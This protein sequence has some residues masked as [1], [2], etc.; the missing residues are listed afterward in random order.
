MNVRS[1]F[2]I[3]AALALVINI[4]ASFI[5]FGSLKSL[6]PGSNQS[7]LLSYLSIFAIIVFSFLLFLISMVSGS[8][9]P[10]MTGQ[11]ET[12]AEMEEENASSAIGVSPETIINIEELKNIAV[13]FIPKGAVKPDE[14]Y[15]LKNFAEETLSQIARSYP[16]IEGL[17]YIK[18]KESDEFIPIGDY[19]YFS[20]KKPTGFKLGETLAGQVAKNKRALNISD[21]PVNYVKAASGLGEGSPLHLYFLPL[22][23]NEETIA[24]IEIAS[25]KELGK[26]SDTLFELAS[27]ELSKALVQ[28]QTRN[29]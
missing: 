22:I 16:I 21:I 13:N 4:G 18:E 14:K 26:E 29:L 2:K 6:S 25:F 1:G 3:L 15:S 23:D 27:I 7:M 24:V 9:A 10:A 11:P 28:L 12:S 8:N 5:L 20:E 17:F 19:A